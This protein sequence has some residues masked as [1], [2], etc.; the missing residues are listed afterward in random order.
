[1]YFK[2]RK[3]SIVQK[4]SFSVGFMVLLTL[5][6]LS[7]Y[8]PTAPY[9]V[10]LSRNV[11]NGFALSILLMMIAPAFVEWS[12]SRYIRAV[13]KNL[14][15]FLRDITNE[16]QSGVPLM[17]ALEKASTQNYGPISAPLQQTMNRISVTSDIET[18]LKWFGEKLVTPQAK[19]LSLILIEAYNT[20]GNITDI[21]ESSLEIFS[22]LSKQKKDRESLTT[23]Y[24]YVVYLGTFVFLIISWVIL[25]KFLVP[26]SELT[27]NT[28]LVTAGLVSDFFNINYYWSI[29]FWAAVLESI[30]GGLIGGKIKFGKLSKGL[31]YA[32]FLLMI[33]ILY[34]NSWLFN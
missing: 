7:K 19:R 27:Q 13:E 25:E 20:G 26:L 29:L 30:A 34:F 28:E 1:M 21:L 23:P 11:N 10:P 17:F 9:W 8:I 32:C 33:T 18:S 12:N 16:V 31:V 15:K 22:L 4:A 14:P 2:E 6:F 24:Q 5:F 3:V